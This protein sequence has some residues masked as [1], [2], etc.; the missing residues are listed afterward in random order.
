MLV[1]RRAPGQS[2]QGLL[3][4]PIRIEL[5]GL[6]NS[7]IR[8]TM[9]SVIGSSAWHFRFRVSHAEHIASI[10]AGSTSCFENGM[11]NSGVFRPWSNLLSCLCGHL[12]LRR[13]VLKF[14]WGIGTASSGGEGDLGRSRPHTRFGSSARSRDSAK[15]TFPSIGPHSGRRYS[16]I[17]WRTFHYSVPVGPHRFARS[18]GRSLHS[19]RCIALRTGSGRAARLGVHRSRRSLR[20]DDAP[21]RIV[22]RRRDL[23]PNS[24]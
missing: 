14:Q 9:N 5:P 8:S 4:Q 17:F 10:R 15:I 1:D 7:M 20:L 16:S 6:R 24:G 13:Q 19:R 12:V 2:D 11:E 22:I 21:T 23:L 3:A 18:S